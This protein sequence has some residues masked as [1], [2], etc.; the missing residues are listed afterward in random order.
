MGPIKSMPETIAIL[1]PAPTPY[2]RKVA[3]QQQQHVN[4]SINATM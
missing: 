4:Q 2:G 3:T 1:S